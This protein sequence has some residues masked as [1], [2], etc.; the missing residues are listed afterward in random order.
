AA[1][2]VGVG[3]EVIAFVQPEGWLVTRF[4][5]GEIVSV[6]RMREPGAIRRVAAALRPVHSGP[7]L[8]GRFDAFRIV[9]EYRST[10]YAHG[11]PVPAEYVR[12]RQVARAIE[13]ARG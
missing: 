3:P 6:E 10:A 13:R 5:E 1:A 7:P 11:A 8:P 4:I 2:A 12:A 9:E